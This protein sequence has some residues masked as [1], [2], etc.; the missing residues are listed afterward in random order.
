MSDVLWCRL[1]ELFI[2]FRTKPIAFPAS[3]ADAMFS[4]I[5]LV[6]FPPTDL[7]VVMVPCFISRPCFHIPLL[8]FRPLQGLFDILVLPRISVNGDICFSHFLLNHNYN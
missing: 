5:A 8:A 4:V 1:D 3:I 2:T 6:K 7:A